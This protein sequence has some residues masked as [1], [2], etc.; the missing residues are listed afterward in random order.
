MPSAT[1]VRRAW[2]GMIVR[3]PDAVQGLGFLIVFLLTFLSNA[4]VP[5]R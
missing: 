4:I 5:I 3:A 1:S 2:I